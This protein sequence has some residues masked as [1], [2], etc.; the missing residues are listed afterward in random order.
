MGSQGKRTDLTLSKVVAQLMLLAF[1]VGGLL[2]AWIVFDSIRRGETTYLP[3]DLLTLVNSDNPQSSTNI[4]GTH[5]PGVPDPGMRES[6]ANSPQLPQP[7]TQVP[8]T[9]SA[10]PEPDGSRGTE[11][12]SGENLDLRTA[13]RRVSV[14]MYATSWCPACKEAKAYMKQ[15]GI[16]YTELNV[17]KNEPARRMH[18]RRNPKG[19]VPTIV[20]DGDEVMVGFSAQGI[21][22]HMDRAARKYM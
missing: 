16:S 10:G 17:E 2:G 19:S 18:R 21:E 7:R 13:R 9:Q 5:E 12:P 11:R 4:F 22:S 6:G 15:K 1:A 8:Q 14:I 3:D 20:F